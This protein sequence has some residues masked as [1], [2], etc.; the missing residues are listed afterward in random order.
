MPSEQ[1]KKRKNYAGFPDLAPAMAHINARKKDQPEE[2]QALLDKWLYELEK[3]DDEMRRLEKIE[4]FSQA[5]CHK[6]S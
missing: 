3:V 5:I 1:N 4:Q 2:K 6:N